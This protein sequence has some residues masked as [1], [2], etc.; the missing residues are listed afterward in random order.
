M[1]DLLIA[2]H[3][4]IYTEN[5]TRM[6]LWFTRIVIGASRSNPLVQENRCIYVYVYVIIVQVLS[7][8]VYMCT[9]VYVYV[10]LSYHCPGAQYYNNYSSYSYHYII[11][12][13]VPRIHF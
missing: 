7:I 5:K 4:T 9:C 2:Y 8:T 12:M 1:Y 3:E 10:A 6:I 11:Y 13:G